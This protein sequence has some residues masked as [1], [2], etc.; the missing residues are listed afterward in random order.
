MSLI[1]EINYECNNMD[2]TKNKTV[3]DKLK[4]GSKVIVNSI[5]GNDVYDMC[6]LDNNCLLVSFVTYLSL[7]NENMQFIRRVDRINSQTFRSGGITANNED[8]L[9]YLS[10]DEFMHRIIMT[11]LELNFIKSIG[12][13]YGNGPSQFAHPGGICYF[14]NHLYVCDFNN[15]RI[16][17]LTKNLEFVASFQIP[18]QAL[19]IKIINSIAF[20]RCNRGTISFY[21]LNTFKKKFQFD[22]TNGPICAVNSFFYNFSIDSVVSGEK[23]VICFDKNGNLD[24]IIESYYLLKDIQFDVNSCAVYYNN[25]ILIATGTSVFKI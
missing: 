2:K 3:K 17:K 12:D 5:T 8:K 4:N 15:Y 10:D 19:Q 16:Q 18:I 24:E 20:I 13:T 11:D 25:Q 23:K 14:N 22:K 1:G 9:I 6:V 21:H 7:Y